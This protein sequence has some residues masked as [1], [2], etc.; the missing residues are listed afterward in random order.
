MD[1]EINSAEIDNGYMMKTFKHHDAITETVPGKF[2]YSKIYLSKHKANDKQYAVKKIC[3]NEMPEFNGNNINQIYNTIKR[4]I[5][6]WSR[7]D[8]DFFVRYYYSWLS[9]ET[10]KYYF[11]IQ[12]DLCWYSLD[13]SIKQMHNYF[14]DTKPKTGWPSV[15][16]YMAGELF[17]EILEAINYLHKQGIIHRSIKPSNILII[18]NNNHKFIKLADFGYATEH[19]TSSQSHTMLAIDDKYMAPE[20]KRS[21]KYCMKSDMYSIGGI[22]QDL[23]NVDINRFV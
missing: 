8:S 19:E 12:M 18:N 17:S 6:L 20:V 10:N 13:E 21:R 15:G 22:A 11:H 4:G 14:K 23:F 5:K 1:Q 9:L 16:Y 3:I 2:L 7:L